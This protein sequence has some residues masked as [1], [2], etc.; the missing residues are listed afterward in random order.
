MIA[1][2]TGLL[3]ETFGH[4]CIVLTDGGIGYRVSLP[5]HTLDALPP[6]GDRVAFYTSMLV[7]EDAQELYGFESF[8]ERQ[9]FEILRGINKIGP[10]AALSVLSAYRPDDLCE[11]VR[12]E[13]LNALKKISGIG[14][15]TAQRLLLELQ[16][17]M[18]TMGP[19]TGSSAGSRLAAPS[20]QLDVMAALANLGYSEAECHAV[21][22]AMFKAEPD[23][24]VGSGIRMALKEL[25][26]GKK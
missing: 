22:A 24:D 12:R 3:L 16:D 8:E 20:A 17:K 6:K 15:K 4:C 2:I 9:T 11:I 1:Y 26:Q 14:A 13:D 23:L 21:V 7:R 5:R 19:H 25:A 18:K 10:K